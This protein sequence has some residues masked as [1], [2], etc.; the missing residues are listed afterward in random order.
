MSPAGAEGAGT[1]LLT[2]LSRWVGL[3]GG[4]VCVRPACIPL[5]TPS[6]VFLKNRSASY[7]TSEMGL[8]IQE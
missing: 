1:C 4:G 2:S 7:F 6:N 3:G 5:L 8:F